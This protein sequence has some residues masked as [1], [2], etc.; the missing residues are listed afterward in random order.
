MAPFALVIN[1]KFQ[2]GHSLTY[3]QRT[4]PI[5][6]TP[7]ILASDKNVETVGKL[8]LFMKSS[9]ATTG[10]RI[11]QRKSKDFIQIKNCKNI[12]KTIK[13]DVKIIKIKND[14][15]DV[16]SIADLVFLVR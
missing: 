12:T 15:R 5:D 3:F 6:Q 11:V 9:I 13:L 8:L 4:G 7:G 16:G 2:K 14:I 1:F 10:Q